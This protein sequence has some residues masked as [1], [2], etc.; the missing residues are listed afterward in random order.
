M[1]I[2]IA[3]V[4]PTKDRP[5]DM[6]RLLKSL[7]EQNSLPE[8]IV[9]VDGSEP[10]I[11]WVCD[12]FDKLNITYVREMPP[13]LA[14]QRNVGMAA[15]E[16]D[17]QVAG[18]LDD[19]L[20]LEPSATANMKEF[21]DKASNEIGGASFCISNQ[22][23]RRHQW[24]SKLF[25]LDGDKHGGITPSGFQCAIPT[26]EHH[27]Q[28]E[29]LYGGATMWRR[30]VVASYSYDEWF[31]GHGLGEDYEY[32]YRVGQQYKLFVVANARTLHHHHEMAESKMYVLGRQQTFNR[33]YIFRQMTGY[34][35]YLFAWSMFGL[36]LLNA[37][38]AL[39]KPGAPT[40]NRLRG[41]IRG[42]WEGLMNPSRSYLGH[43][44]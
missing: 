16:A 24:L 28:V 21:W 37:F 38:A 15:L 34:S 6:E 23:P 44:K 31:A 42:I 9:V 12:K 36:V 43:W 7:S 29:W 10:P 20:E 14:R 17:I 40:V 41:N 1:T 35:G 11:K 3:Y 8:Q 18:Y 32:S 5:D 19:D 39:R 2:K 33:F 30:E 22:N 27:T 26:V 25:L 4:I 13:S